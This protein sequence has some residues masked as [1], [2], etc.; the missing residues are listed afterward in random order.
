MKRSYPLEGAPSIR[1]EGVQRSSKFPV[2]PPVLLVSPL[3][4]GLTR[5]PPVEPGHSH[6]GGTRRPHSLQGTHSLN[7]IMSCVLC[8]LSCVMCHVSCVMCH[9]S[10]IMCHVSCVM[11]NIMPRMS[12]P[13]APRCR[14]SS[15]VML[16]C[17]PARRPGPSQER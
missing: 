16:T 12:R 8:P 2:E 10:C 7:N 9:V 13:A 1:P 5:L 6:A 15:R 17:T 4:P 14:G 3:T 11:C